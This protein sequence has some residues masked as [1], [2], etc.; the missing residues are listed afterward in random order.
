[1]TKNVGCAYP[2]EDANLREGAL[3]NKYSKS[4]F[5]SEIK[6]YFIVLGA[7]D[8]A[9]FLRITPEIFSSFQIWWNSSFAC[10]KSLSVHDI[11]CMV[12]RILR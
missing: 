7:I 11:K 1:M 6:C 8:T 12:Y 10:S 5:S 4:L 9:A 3:L 2:R